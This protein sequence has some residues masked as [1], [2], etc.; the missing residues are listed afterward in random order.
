MPRVSS[1]E[2]IRGVVI[3]SSAG[4]S[5]RIGINQAP[6]VWLKAGDVVEV[7]VPSIGILPTR[8]SPNSHFCTWPT[9]GRHAVKEITDATVVKGLQWNLFLVLSQ[10]SLRSVAGLN[11][12][13]CFF[14]RL[15]Q[16]AQSHFDLMQFCDV[17]NHTGVLV[18]RRPDEL[19]GAQ[20][21]KAVWSAETAP[22]EK[23]T[24]GQNSRSGPALAN[25]F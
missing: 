6:P 15:F 10:I 13:T 18:P 14:T 24:I 20:A 2:V 25:S 21:Q 23:R 1:V 22:I 5:A 7:K 11:M 19:G 8:W 4:A 16:R 3:F 9:D 17:C 12:A